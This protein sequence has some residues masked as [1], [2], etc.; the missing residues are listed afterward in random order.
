MVLIFN[1]IQA[2]FADVTNWFYERTHARGLDVRAYYQKKQKNELSLPPFK[3]IKRTHT[4]IRY[5]F[6]P[7]L[8]FFFLLL[9]KQKQQQQ[10]QLSGRDI[11]CVPNALFL[12]RD[13]DFVQSFE[14]R[15]GRH[16][17]YRM[18]LNLSNPLFAIFFKI[19]K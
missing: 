18:Y 2:L 10:Q 13:R 3:K 9:F 1:S 17:L 16:F 19:R 12:Y 15:H 5:S 6:P 8:I 4:S 14:S 7:R 11:I